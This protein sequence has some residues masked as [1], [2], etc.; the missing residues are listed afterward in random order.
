MSLAKKLNLKPGMTLRAVGK[1]PG[2]DLDDVL[3]TTSAKADA[4]LV[5]V[6]TLTDVDAKCEPVVVAA[7]ADRLAWIAYPKAG[8]LRHRLEPR[9]SLETPARPRDSG[10]STGRARFGV[11]RH[12][13]PSEAVNGGPKHARVGAM[14]ARWHAAHRLARGATL[15]E[16]TRWHVAHQKACA[17][18][19]MPASI[20]AASGASQKPAP[21]SA[22]AVAAGFG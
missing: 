5:F 15:K 4:L 19:E 8:Q 17:C 13:L 12:A 1:P 18:R 21:A 9:H 10:C 3:L 20:R 2:I 7:K 22:K 6:K 11:E 16:R 14:N